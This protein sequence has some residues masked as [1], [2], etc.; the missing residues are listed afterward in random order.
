MEERQILFAHEPGRKPL[1]AI[2]RM[3]IHS[4]IRELEQLGY[5]EK[6]CS[7]I[8]PAN[9][10]RINELIG[11]GAMPA[12][13]ALEHYRACDRLG[14][15]DQQI[16]AAGLHAGENIADALLVASRQLGPS[17]ERSAWDMIAA[18]YR[19]SKRIYDGGSVQYVKLSSNTL[20]I[21]YRENPLFSVRYYRIAYDG[22][23]RRAFE[24]VGV[25]V[26][27]F[28]LTTY[29]PEGAEIEARIR[30]KE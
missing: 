5:Y 8:G 6:Y 24:N 12:E 26:T 20:Q 3:L 23:I 7:V 1:V 2:R 25:Q 29:R 9:L 10:A 30:W 27:E 4:S 28:R 15:S 11:P 19:M 16:Y 18:F 21:E 17:A 13:L 14:L 22:F